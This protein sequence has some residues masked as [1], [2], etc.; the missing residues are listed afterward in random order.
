M[1][2]A[3]FERL[4]AEA[5]DSLPEQFLVHLE[6]VEVVIDC[7]PSAEDLADAGLEG[8]PPESLLGLY[9]GVPLTERDSSYAALP[10]RI[11]LYQGSIE[12]V[13]GDDP[14]AVRAEV[15]ATVIHEIA[16]YYGISDE[17]LEEMGWD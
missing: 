15:Q 10:D 1:N 5:L 4:A 3:R 8:E 13:A 2:E 14:E 17:R 11:T 9:F 12:A 7:L 16:H 6:N